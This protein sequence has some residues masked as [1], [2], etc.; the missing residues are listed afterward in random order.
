MEIGITFA[1]IEMSLSNVFGVACENYGHK[2]CDDSKNVAQNKIAIAPNHS[3]SLECVE[4]MD[5]QLLRLPTQLHFFLFQSFILVHGRTQN[6]EFVN[7]K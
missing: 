5:C 7:Y 1:T 4:L 3:P 6:T 2:K